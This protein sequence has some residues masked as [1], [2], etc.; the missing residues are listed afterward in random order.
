MTRS[1]RGFGRLR[2]CQPSERWQASYVGPD[3]KLYKAPHTFSAKVDAEAW[4]TDRR[5]EIDREFWSPP[6][7]AEQK[8]AAAGQKKSAAERFDAY[9]KRWLATRTVRGR[10][11][12]P[13]TV[14]HYQA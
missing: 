13:R 11:L 14:D 6:A 12:K 9:A 1:R 2:K 4:L 7:T 10:P 5:R 3:D 8:K